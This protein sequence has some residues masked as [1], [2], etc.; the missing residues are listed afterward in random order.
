MRLI[1]GSKEDQ[2]SVAMSERLLETVDF[3]PLDGNN[4]ILR[5]GDYLF[6]Y[7]QRRH[8]YMDTL[9]SGLDGIS[10]AIDVVIFLSRHSSAADIK[11]LT[12]HPTGNFSEA[13]LG[14]TVGR[15]SPTAPYDMTSALLEMH[16]TYRGEEFKVTYEATHHGPALDIPHFYMEIGTTETQW[17]NPEAQ[18]DIIRGI[19]AE[20]RNFNG[21]FVGIG[22]GHYMPKITEYSI[23]NTIAMGHM[24]SKHALENISEELIRQ[25]VEK[26]PGC[27]GFVI[28]RKGTKSRAREIVMS[29]ADSLGL[30]IIRI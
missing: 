4:S 8:L 30:E 25:S 24:I 6:S 1:I 27:R 2:A 5:H 21:A 17:N 19:F 18:D 26:T 20:R 29:V 15:L 23:E 28:D 16:S 14:G 9:D 13:K 12:V 10:Q 11:S 3:Q 7:I 22:G